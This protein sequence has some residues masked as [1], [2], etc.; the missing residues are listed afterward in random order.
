MQ[1]QFT[2]QK[3][4]IKTKIELWQAS[5]TTIEL[6]VGHTLR[7]VS[8]EITSYINSLIEQAAGISFSA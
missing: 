8:S 5:R 1:M 3:A 6:S 4:E 2:P 7:E